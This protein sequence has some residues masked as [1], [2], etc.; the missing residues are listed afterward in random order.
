MSLRPFHL[1]ADL[2]L[3]AKLLPAAFQCSGESGL[4]LN[5]DAGE[6]VLNLVREA[7]SL[8]NGCVWHFVMS[9]GGN[10]SAMA[11]G[12]SGMVEAGQESSSHDWMVAQSALA[13]R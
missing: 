11:T 9:S 6:V 8:G 4:P 12:L 13:P 1:P 5:D 7:R 3:M 2:S 10:F